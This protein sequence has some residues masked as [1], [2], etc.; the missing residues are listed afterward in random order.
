MQREYDNQTGKTK[1]LETSSQQVANFGPYFHT[2]D[3]LLDADGNEAEITYLEYRSGQLLVKLNRQVNGE[4]TLKGPK[5][6]KCRILG[7]V[8]TFLELG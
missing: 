5:P 6:I 8:G 7:N 3:K 1:T 2:G 4:L